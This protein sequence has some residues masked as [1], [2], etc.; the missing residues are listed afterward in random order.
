MSTNNA[1]LHQA[2]TWGRYIHEVLHI[3]LV[4]GHSKAVLTGVLIRCS[5][6]SDLTMVSVVVPVSR[7]YGTA[8]LLWSD[9]SFGTVL[10]RYRSQLLYRVEFSAQGKQEL[11]RERV[12]QKRFWLI[13]GSRNVSWVKKMMMFRTDYLT[14][15][16]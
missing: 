2:R 16:T 14:L 11:R 13:V 15:N 6:E 3:H 7:F 1:I 5:S 8:R 4:V 9:T 10:E 12:R